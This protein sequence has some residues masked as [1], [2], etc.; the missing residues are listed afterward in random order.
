MKCL[1]AQH[2]MLQV[3][4]TELSPQTASHLET[5]ADCRAFAQTANDLCRLSDLEPPS[6]LDRTVLQDVCGEMRRK[7]V[8][9]PQPR[10]FV[11]IGPLSWGVAAAAVAI[12]ALSALLQRQE[13]VPAPPVVAAEVQSWSLGELDEDLELL[14]AQLAVESVM[15][16]ASNGS[17]SANGDVSLDQAIWELDATLSFEKEA[18]QL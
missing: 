6:S 4:P 11:W 1:D 13:S 7:T 8:V 14:E 3:A 18:W 17:E 16:T 5:C 9:A 12:F 2:E 10:R 15:L